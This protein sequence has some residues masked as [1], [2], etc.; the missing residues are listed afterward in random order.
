MIQHKATFSWNVKDP[1]GVWV[2]RGGTAK[3]V[4]LDR[5]YMDLHINPDHTDPMVQTKWSVLN[6][7]YHAVTKTG[8]GHGGSTGSEGTDEVD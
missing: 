5:I 7:K 8:T 3:F 2:V 4:E 1:H 6:L